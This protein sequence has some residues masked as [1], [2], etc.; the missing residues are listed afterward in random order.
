MISICDLD[1]KQ[2][3]ASGHEYR[4]LQ[5]RKSTSRHES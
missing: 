5:Q 2:T 4:A 3:I 1:T